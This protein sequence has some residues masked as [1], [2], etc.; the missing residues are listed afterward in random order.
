MNTKEKFEK[1][2]ERASELKK[3]GTLDLSMEEDLSI[4]VMNLISLEEHLFFTAKKTGKSEYLGMLDEV[5]S[6]RADLLGKMITKG[7][8]ETW[9]VSKHLL[10]AAMRLMEVGTKLRSK[11]KIEE[12]DDAFAKAYKSYSLFWAVRLAN[13]ESERGEGKAEE[14]KPWTVDDIVNSLVDCCNEK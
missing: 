14:K 7:E 10:A 12:A 2:V 8:G 5:R 1:L 9:C 3:S 13:Q 4:A 6:M 11:G